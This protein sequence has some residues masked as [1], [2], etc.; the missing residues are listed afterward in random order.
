MATSPVYDPGYRA[1]WSILANPEAR[2]ISVEKDGWETV[3]TIRPKAILVTDQDI[4]D[5]ASGKSL[6]DAGA[7]MIAIVNHPGV[8]CLLNRGKGSYFSGCIED[9]N[10]DGFFDTFFKVNQTKPQFLSAIRQTR[11]K[12]VVVNPVK[13]NDVAN[14]SE[15]P[16]TDIVIYYYS[17]SGITGAHRFQICVMRQPGNNIWDDQKEGRACQPAIKV[18]NDAFPKTLLIYGRTVTLQSFDGEKINLR[19]SGFDKDF[20]ILL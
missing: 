18:E 8:Y 2:D 14:A 12:D 1:G 10:S 15:I 3:F 16:V 9:K 4:V 5:S 6:L 7:K 20:D 17:R 19:I 11:A 13:F